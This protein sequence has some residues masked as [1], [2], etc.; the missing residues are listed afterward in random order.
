MMSQTSSEKIQGLQR[1]LF[2]SVWMT[3]EWIDS[4][5]LDER[6]PGPRVVVC[7]EE[8]PSDAEWDACRSLLTDML[9]IAGFTE[10]K[11]ILEKRRG[12]TVKPGEVLVLD[13]E[14]F[15]RI[16]SEIAPWRLELGR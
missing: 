2:E 14:I 3:S 10:S 7:A 12:G 16:A 1:A 13:N 15:K 9:E 4:I 5:L 6:G 11:T 8:L